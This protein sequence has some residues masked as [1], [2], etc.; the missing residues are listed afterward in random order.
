M[1]SLHLL[2]FIG[3][4]SSGLLVSAQPTDAQSIIT[5]SFTPNG[6]LTPALA[7]QLPQAN[8]QFQI[9]P[10][11]I[12]ALFANQRIHVDLILQSGRTESLGVVTTTDFIQS[13]TR[14]P[15]VDP[16]MKIMLNEETAR[17]IALS[18][19]PL[20]SLIHAINSGEMRYEIT[21]PRMG[22]RS[23]VDGTMGLFS[24]FITSISR[25]IAG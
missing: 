18:E 9:I 3:M 25:I 21:P 14:Y 5:T 10:R 23:V 2:L 22:I 1:R 15:P 16:T 19:N 8:A 7:A 17:E 13:I 11:T 6:E 24:Q 20:G 4:I 12:R